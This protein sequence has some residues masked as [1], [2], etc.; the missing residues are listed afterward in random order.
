MFL[1]ATLTERLRENSTKRTFS[2]QT[3]NYFKNSAKHHKKYEERYMQ[4]FRQGAMGAPPQK[5]VLRI[6][7]ILIWIRILGS[8]SW[9]NGSGSC[10][11]Y[12][13]PKYDLFCYLWGKYMYMSVNVSLIVLKKMYDF[14]M[15][16]VDFCE[17]FPRFWLIFATRIRIRSKRI[18]I[19]NTARNT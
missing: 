9:N 2:C 11:K 3:S 4:G 15:I 16:L 18:R 5:P 17:N 19:R 7:F 1:A 10:S 13:S 8:V 14:L 12:I 6:R